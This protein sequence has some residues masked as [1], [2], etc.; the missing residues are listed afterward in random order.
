MCTNKQ[1]LKKL[2]SAL[3]KKYPDIILERNM[4]HYTC[5]RFFEIRS[6]GYYWKKII[7]KDT[8]LQVY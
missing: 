2:F 1:V 6:R 4:H 3:L 5:C 7:E 8:G